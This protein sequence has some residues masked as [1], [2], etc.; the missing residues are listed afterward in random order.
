MCHTENIKIGMN[1][2][3]G[4]FTRYKGIIILYIYILHIKDYCSYIIII[5]FNQFIDFVC[6]VFIFKCIEMPLL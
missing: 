2:I 6:K 4:H 1:G 3:T 5:F